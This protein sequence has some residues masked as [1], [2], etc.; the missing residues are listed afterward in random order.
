VDGRQSG[1]YPETGFGEV[2]APVDYTEN[3]RS[4][5]D[6]SRLHSQSVL[7]PDY[8][9]NGA[10]AAGMCVH[11]KFGKYRTQKCASRAATLEQIAYNS[12]TQATIALG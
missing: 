12:M 10:G 2:A 9:N 1:N 5:G 8:A 3:N 4:I 6:K 7:T 11:P